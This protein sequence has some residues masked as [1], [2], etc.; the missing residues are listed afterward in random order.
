MNVTAHKEIDAQKRQEILAP[1]VS[2][3]RSKTHVDKS[4]LP[5]KKKFENLNLQRQ[6]SSLTLKPHIAETSSKPTHLEIDESKSV[7]VAENA[8]Q[9]NL[10][11][12]TAIINKIANKLPQ[13]APVQVN[14]ISQH[15]T[16]A[17]TEININKNTIEKVDSNENLKF[18]NKIVFKKKFLNFS[19]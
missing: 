18:D 10:V 19:K 16:K 13:K 15:L 1:R 6:K 7:A 8:I 5:T 4:L 3:L 9:N 14:S 12:N 17:T 2:L 11:N